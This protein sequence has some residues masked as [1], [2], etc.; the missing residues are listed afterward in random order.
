MVGPLAHILVKALNEIQS[1]DRGDLVGALVTLDVLNEED[2]YYAEGV[3]RSGTLL[4]VT[5]AAHL[6][7]RAEDVLL[8][9]GA[10]DIRARAW[11]W[12]QQGWQHF[13]PTLEPYSVH[14]LERERYGH[15]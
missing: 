4:A 15:A 11:L 12:R 6:T 14:E 10:V 2:E 7:E 1:E 9:H 5:T 3:R 13:I 8:L